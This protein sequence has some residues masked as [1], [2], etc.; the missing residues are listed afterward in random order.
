MEDTAESLIV[1]AWLA[2]S[3][4]YSNPRPVSP[5]DPASPKS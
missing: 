3:A 5:K 4:W 1:E 2:M